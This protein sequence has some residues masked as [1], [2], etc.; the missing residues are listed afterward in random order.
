MIIERFHKNCVDKTVPLI[1]FLFSSFLVI[2]ITNLTSLSI[3]SILFLF[4]TLVL[5]HKSVFKKTVII[6]LLVILVVVFINLLLN[7]TFTFDSM[8]HFLPKGISLSIIVTSA[9]AVFAFLPTYQL[10]RISIVATR[11]QNASLAI[12][13]GFRTFPV[14][15]ELSKK[16]FI[17]IKI[18]NATN[19]IVDFV[20][21]FITNIIIDFFSFL[22]DYI[23]RF[24]FIKIENKV[25]PQS[26]SFSL[27]ITCIYLL[28]TILF[29]YEN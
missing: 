18:R 16:I 22:E 7:L 4:V 9:I 29:I 11:S 27:F 14:F 1:L 28:T 6:S 21:L 10:Y 20:N 13:T 23:N 2:F 19:S 26:F 8:I 3:I 17:S 5:F 15:F 25:H 12:L 24:S